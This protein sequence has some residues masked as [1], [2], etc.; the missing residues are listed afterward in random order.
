MKRIVVSTVAIILIALTLKAAKNI[1]LSAS[2]ENVIAQMNYC[3]YALTNIIYDQSMATLQHESDQIE[4]NL[5]EENIVGLEHI[6]EFRNDLLSA[7]QDFMITDEERQLTKKLMSMRQ[8][9]MKWQALSNAFDP[10]MVLTNN[11]YSAAFN[12]LTTATRSAIEYNL[13]Q[14][15]LR[16]EELQAMWK[17]RKENLEGIKRMRVKAHNYIHELYKSYHLKESYRLTVE[18]AKSFKSYL[19]EKSVPKKIRLLENRRSVYKD[20]AFYYYHLGMAYLDNGDWTKA[21]LNFDI[22][23]NMYAK[24]PI[25]RHDEMSGCIALAELANEKDLSNQEKMRLISE[26]LSSMPSNSSALLQCAL[27]LI[28]DLGMEVDGYKLILSGID[29]PEGTDRSVLFLAAV[30]LLPKIKQYAQLYD[31]M[32]SSMDQLT[33]VY[34]DCA[35][36]FAYLVNTRKF[37]WLD[38]NPLIQ[39]DNIGEYKRN[40]LTRIF[41]ATRW[42]SSADRKIEDDLKINLP[43]NLNWNDGDFRAY[44]EEHSEDE[45]NIK[46]LKVSLNDGIPIDDVNDVEDFKKYP[47]LKYLFLDVLKP[48]KL[49]RV[50]PNLDYAKIESGEFPYLY[51]FNLDG[52]DEEKDKKKIK[53]RKKIIEFCKDNEMSTDYTHLSCKAVKKRNVALGNIGGVKATFV[54]DTLAYYPHHTPS[55][56]GYYLR[57]V[58]NSGLTIMYTFDWEDRWFQNVDYLWPYFYSYDKRRVFYKKEY[59]EEYEVA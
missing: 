32:I 45:M 40:F 13:A 51:N 17:L 4:S 16:M 1:S 5:K 11:P 26:V 46:E 10:A 38:I 6:H 9:N 15:E 47:N 23:R 21:K 14:N 56:E 33:S 29:D 20:M 37:A 18:S 8:D 7:I 53:R 30:K 28:N 24:A 43:S 59:L 27:V 39:F 22:Y 35:T 3:M 49:F 34:S 36:Y 48:G 50:K 42:F 55:M 12:V 58:F 57:L 52:N 2:Q 44:V 25:F 31:A 54:G 19:K 41:M